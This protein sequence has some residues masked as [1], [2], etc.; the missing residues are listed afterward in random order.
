MMVYVCDSCSSD[1]LQLS[2]IVLVLVLGMIV[3]QVIELLI[4]LTPLLVTITVATGG[5]G[6]KR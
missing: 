2:I 5:L 4:V 1:G 3:L 6:T